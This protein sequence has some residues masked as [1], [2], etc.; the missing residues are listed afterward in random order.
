MEIKYLILMLI[1][2]FFMHVWD[3]FGRQGIM[4]QMKQKSWW[5]EHAP[6]YVYHNDYIM[7]LL[8]HAFSWSVFVMIPVAIPAFYYNNHYLLGVMI[9]LL[10]FNTAFHAFIDDMKCNQHKINLVYDQIAHIAQILLTWTVGVA[11]L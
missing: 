10:L 2:M 9:P 1:A 8:A 6:A 3:D 7:A 4:A 5:K 11:F